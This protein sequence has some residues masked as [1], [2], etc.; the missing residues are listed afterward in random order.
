[1]HKYE[2]KQEDYIFIKLDKEPG[3]EYGKCDI[4]ANR[5]DSVFIGIAHIICRAAELM[6]RDATT[7]FCKVAEVLY[8]QGE[9]D[10]SNSN[11]VGSL[12]QEL[13]DSNS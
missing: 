10:D 5:E 7:V 12:Q 1:M 9:T 4:T 3:D 13:S 11:H 8:G 2:L 6:G